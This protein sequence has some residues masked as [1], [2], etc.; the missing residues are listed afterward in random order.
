MSDGKYDGWKMSQE[1]NKE[2]EEKDSVTVQISLEIPRY[3]YITFDTDGEIG[4]AS[5]YEYADINKHRITRKYKL[6]D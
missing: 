6:C 5:Q 1:L 4:Y 2:Q 3:V